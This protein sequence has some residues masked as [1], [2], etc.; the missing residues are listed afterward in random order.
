MLSKLGGGGL[1]Q[2]GEGFLEEVTN[3]LFLKIK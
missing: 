3:K 2:A 1:T